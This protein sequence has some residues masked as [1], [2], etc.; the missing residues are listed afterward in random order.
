MKKSPL[1]AAAILLAANIS[2]YGQIITVTAPTA[3]DGWCIGSTYAITW[4]SSAPIP[5]PMTIRLRR[6]GPDNRDTEALVIVRRM[7]NS[8]LFRWTIPATVAPGE[9]LI[10]IWTVR[11]T[12]EDVSGD[13]ARFSILVRAN[14]V[15]G[16]QEDPGTGQPG[17]GPAALRSDLELAGVGVEYD[18]TRIVAWVRNNGPDALADRDVKFRLNFPERGGGEQILTRPLT[19]PVG[20]ERSV[21]MV[22]MDASVF[23]DSGLRTSVAIDTS[24]SRIQ[25]PNRLNQHRDVR[26]C[27]LD[28]RCDLDNLQLA[29]VYSYVFR[30][31][32]F[33]VT[34]S[35]HVRHNLPRAVNNIR[36]KV[37]YHGPSGLLAGHG[38]SVT[39]T[40]PTLAA[41][42]VWTKSQEMRFGETG[43]S[44]T[45]QPKIS[46]GTTYQIVATLD[47]PGNAFCDTIPRNDTARLN[48]RFPD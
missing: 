41:G 44:H 23:P 14:P 10:R 25:D 11:E 2:L 1:L 37:E 38:N 24:L 15:P 32:P 40:I 35:I 26:L 5:D 30:D 19:I 42:E 27:V 29:R 48:F 20:Q 21:P 47:D 7:E 43:E 8:G 46:K 45:G 28:T 13:S 16:D 39:Y 17:T 33:K 3:S 31:L 18:G 9:Y 34:F 36:V 6:V 22:V 12:G 4:T